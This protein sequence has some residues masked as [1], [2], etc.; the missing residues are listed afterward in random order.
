MTTLRPSL[1]ASAIASIGSL[2][3]FSTFAQSASQQAY[4][5]VINLK[6]GPMASVIPPITS[7]NPPDPSTP[8]PPVVVP[9]PVSALA[10]PGLDVLGVCVLAGLVGYVAWRKRKSG[11]FRALSVVLMMGAAGLA[12][13]GSDGWIQAVRAANPF[14]MDIPSGGTVTSTVNWAD[15][16]TPQ[17]IVNNTNVRMK[18]LSNANNSETAAGSCAVDA[19][20]AP[21]ESCTTQAVCTPL[22]NVLSIV[23]APTV[24][25]SSSKRLAEYRTLEDPE[26]RIT[27]IYNAF[28][29]FVINPPQVDPLL[30]P[31]PS[32]E[33]VSYVPEVENWALN[34]AGTDLETENLD[35][36]GR[37]TATVTATAPE[38]YVFE[39]TL[40]PTY[41]WTQAYTGCSVRDLSRSE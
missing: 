38:G 13:Q 31:E 27:R 11:G 19:E 5:C 28:I 39:S 18:I 35:A 20:I 29:P 22:L 24:G 21:G 12:T 37:G 7:P 4:S 3:S 41:T 33:L 15:I 30:T 23:E 17:T 10:V 1:L 9:V 6:Y 34:D 36:V 16:P 26:S 2:A 25:C 32:V 14:N 8:I 40:A